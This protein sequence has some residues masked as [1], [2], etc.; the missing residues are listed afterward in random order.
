MKIA[1]IGTGHMGSWFI[2][3]L[4][5]KHDLAIYDKNDNA[6]SK[7]SDINKLTDLSMIEEFKPQIV[8]NAVS[9]KNTIPTF[10]EIS[11]YIEKD[12]ILV[13]IA[14]IKGDIADYYTE[15]KVRFASLHPMFGP[16]FTDMEYL[17][18]ENAVII[19]ESDPDA[20]LFFK[21]LFESYG[22][23][24]FN[25]SFKKHDSLMS[26]SLTL[27]FASSIVFSACVNTNT[28]PGTT[29]TKHRDIATKLLEE[30]D[31]L[32]SEVLF[33]PYSMQ[34]LEK[35]CSRLEFLKHVIRARDY[36]EAE[37]FFSKLRDNLE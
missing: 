30:D 18:D 29:F 2:K 11:K 3:V 28:V 1:I 19:S 7:L 15:S 35:I 37:K 8:I 32:L 12:C 9:L 16:R 26:Y 34:Q 17:K 36:E 25:Y 33:N 24:I 10:K 23:T 6:M 5:K 4:N 20:Q 31:Y 27:P 22:I 21:E 14:S 13:D